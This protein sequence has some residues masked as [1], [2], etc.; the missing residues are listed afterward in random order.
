MESGGPA[1]GLGEVGR[2]MR[3]A[4]GIERVREVFPGAVK[5]REDLLKGLEHLGGP[6]GWPGWV[7]RSSQMAGGVGMPS[8]RDGRDSE[9]PQEGQEV[10]D[11]LQVEREW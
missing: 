3:W 1:G 9:S 11:T 5:G 4:V 8:R 2:P 10:W 7:G 6:P